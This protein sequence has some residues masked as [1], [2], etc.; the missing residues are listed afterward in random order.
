MAYGQ[1]AGHCSKYFIE[2]S[3][4]DINHRR[5]VYNVA[6]LGEEEEEAKRKKEEEEELAAMEDDEE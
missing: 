5:T 1:K 6:R 3:E 4:N 2:M